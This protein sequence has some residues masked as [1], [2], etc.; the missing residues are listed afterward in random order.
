M[1]EAVDT[2]PRRYGG[3][4]QL[5][6]LPFTVLGLLC[7]ALLL[8]LLLEGFGM[9]FVWPDNHNLHAQIL[10]KQD[11][12]DLART[13]WP[14][15]WRSI[16][17]TWLDTKRSVQLTAL[18][19]PWI[20]LQGR[21]SAVPSILGHKTPRLSWI[22]ER[23]WLKEALSAARHSALSVGIRSL[24]LLQALPLLILSVLVGTVDGLVRRQVRRFNVQ[25]ES[26]YLH[27]RAK[28]LFLPLALLPGFMYLVL[29]VSLSIAS[30][31][32]VSAILSG[33]MAA[34]VVGSFKKHL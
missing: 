4:T 11:R 16:S 7:A 20:E 33:L 1:N 10:Y 30:F 31:A 26:G 22:K 15:R 3:F 17:R 19:N 25:R 8:R 28:A 2:R 32:I 34:I 5:L 24:L 9:L 21:L 13:P 27:H 29:P 18:S 12:R 23:S 14:D 6:L